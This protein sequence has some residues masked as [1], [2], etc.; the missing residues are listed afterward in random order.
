MQRCVRP[1]GGSSPRPLAGLLAVVAVMLAVSVASITQQ[2]AGASER[3]PDPRAQIVL[4]CD[5][6]ALDGSL[7]VYVVLDDRGTAPTRFT[8]TSRIA[9][10]PT[11]S[12]SHVVAAG[13][14]EILA[15]EVPGGAD[16]TIRV[17]NVDDA[18]I[19]RRREPVAECAGV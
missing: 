11:V 18:S 7:D 3:V 16:A 14:V 17:T 4:S 12:A 15:F 2:F 6:G 5:D 13:D 8:V 1:S 9:D 10:G 19:D